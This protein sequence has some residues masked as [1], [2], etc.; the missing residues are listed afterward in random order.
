MRIG[1]D[2]IMLTKKDGVCSV[3]LMSQT[4]LDSECVKDVN[5]YL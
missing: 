5:I 1:K 2:L 3:L 4:F